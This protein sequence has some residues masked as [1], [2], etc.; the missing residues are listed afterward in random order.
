MRLSARVYYQ[1]TLRSEISRK[2][3]SPLP[4]KQNKE[5]NLALRNT[6]SPSSSKSERNPN[7]E[8][9]RNTTTTIAKP[10]FRGVTHNIIQKGAFT[11]RH[12]R[13]SKI[14]TKAKKPNRVIF[15]GCRCRD[16]DPC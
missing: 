7:E 1:H 12:T 5:T 16:V 11:Q 3:T 15:W 10:N 2:E 4:T 13:Q 8:V 6:I 14:T 9:V